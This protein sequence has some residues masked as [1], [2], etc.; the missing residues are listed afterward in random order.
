MQLRVSMRKPADL[1]GG[2]PEQTQRAGRTPV[3]R[4][5]RLPRPGDK[6]ANCCQRSTVRSAPELGEPNKGSSS[7]SR[8][9]ALAARMRILRPL[10]APAHGGERRNHAVSARAL[11]ALRR[12]RL[13]R[14]PGPDPVSRAGPRTVRR[15][16]GGAAA[17]S[18]GPSQGVFHFRSV[19]TARRLMIVG[20]C[21]EPRQVAEEQPPFRGEDWRGGNDE[22]V[23]VV[24]TGTTR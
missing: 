20:V 15:S 3:R 23:Q 24:D 18:S 8:A 5:R 12:R 22:P 4:D 11:A 6:V 10:A 14:P 17:L 19:Q 13:R 2:P 16:R 7:P 1:A 21:Q 9:L